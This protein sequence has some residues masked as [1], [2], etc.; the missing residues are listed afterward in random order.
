MNMTKLHTKHQ[1]APYASLVLHDI[2]GSTIRAASGSLW[3]TMEGDARDIILGPGQ[4]FTIERDGLTVLAAHTASEVEVRVPQKT[5][6]PWARFVGFIDRNF[7][8]AALRPARK[9]VY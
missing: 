2:R 8:P 1:L 5:F 9:W 4:S 6:G 3:L 7:G